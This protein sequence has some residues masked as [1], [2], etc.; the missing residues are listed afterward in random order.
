MEDS[1]HI[2][3]S[4]NSDFEKP[5]WKRAYEK[6]SSHPTYFILAAC[7][8]GILL[9]GGGTYFV[10]T[11]SS[12]ENVSGDL[13]PLPTLPE[14]SSSFLFPSNTPNGAS[15]GSGTASP[16]TIANVTVVPLTPTIT[17]TPT[18]NPTATWSAFISSQYGYSIDYP[19]NWV[20]TPTTSGDQLIVQYT[21]FNPNTVSTASSS[22]TVS[23]SNRTAA[24]SLAVYTATGVPLTIGTISATM[25]TTQDSNGNV[26]YRVVIPDGTANSIVIFGR[27]AYQTIF[28]QMV[29]TFE[30][31]GSTN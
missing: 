15:G 13:P 6:I 29:Q 30:F 21:L 26:A 25:Q 4:W 20:A 5:W 10:A 24:Q 8:S 3:V 2:S 17:S 12:A 7:A 11:Q 31:L 19:P 28:N 22:I 1:S 18:V 27:Q 9:F 14:N 23:Y 16:S